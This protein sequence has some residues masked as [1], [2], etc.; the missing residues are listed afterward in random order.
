MCEKMLNWRP[1][2]EG[3][4]KDSFTTCSIYLCAKNS[5]IR[6]QKGSRACKEKFPGHVRMKAHLSSPKAV[7]IWTQLSYTTIIQLRYH[8]FHPRDPIHFRH[9][10]YI[11]STW[12]NYGTK[13]PS[14]IP[15]Q[16]LLLCTLFCSNAS[17]YMPTDIFHSAGYNSKGL[18]IKHVSN[19]RC[20][21]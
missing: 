1:L 12:C 2:N 20:Q 3:Y 11:P 16:Y 13:P 9:R 19:K 8:S 18:Y 17:W 21:T 6:G 4:N 10:T 14:R 15:C 7:T 5:W